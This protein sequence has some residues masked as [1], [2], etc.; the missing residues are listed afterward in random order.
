MSKRRAKMSFY[1]AFRDHAGGN[2]EMATTYQCPIYGGSS[3]VEGVTNIIS[4]QQLPTDYLLK[5]G[6]FKFKILFTPCHTRDSLCYYLIEQEGQ[7]GSV[8]TGDTLFLA[9]CGRFFEGKH[10]RRLAT[11]PASHFHR[12]GRRN[13]CSPTEHC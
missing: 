4:D 10:I 9:G 13:E 11:V 5:I 7:A 12:N 3:Q 1:F 2:A 6:N 8:F